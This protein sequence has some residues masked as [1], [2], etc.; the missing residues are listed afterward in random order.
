M[1]ISDNHLFPIIK[2]NMSGDE[3]NINKL[4]LFVNFVVKFKN[5]T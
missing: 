1:K 2:Y 4:K 5:S 3:T